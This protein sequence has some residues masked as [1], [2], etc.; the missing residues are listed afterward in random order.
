MCLNRAVSLPRRRYDKGVDDPASLPFLRSA[1]LL[2]AVAWM[3]LYLLSFYSPIL[4]YP[5]YALACPVL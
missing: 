2:G 1:W 5:A 4:S 3:G